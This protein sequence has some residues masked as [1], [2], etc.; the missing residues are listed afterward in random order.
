MA[1]SVNPF[2]DKDIAYK[3]QKE[4]RTVLRW[5]EEGLPF[6]EVELGSLA[7]ISELI[8]KRDFSCEIKMDQEFFDD[9][10]REAMWQM[11]VR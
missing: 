9:L 8:P 10:S 3:A 11:N 2:F 5:A 4:F 1:V 7:D 6:V